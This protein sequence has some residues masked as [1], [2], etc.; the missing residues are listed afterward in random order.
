M[1]VD[2]LA[3]YLEG[4]GLYGDDLDPE[5]IAH[6]YADEREGYASLGAAD[7]AR[8]R[9][10]YHAWNVLHGYAHLQQDPHWHALGFGS[11]YG[12]EFLPVIS[13]LDSL[14]IVEPSDVFVAENVHGIP[15]EY[16]KPAPDG[17]LPLEDDAFDLITCLGVLHHIPN[18]TWG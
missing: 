10:V 8:Y 17:G 5:G 14:T 1:P 13:R 7:S 16:V 3:P 9:Y 11:A 12:D 2:E 15:A 4:R 6:W 18:V